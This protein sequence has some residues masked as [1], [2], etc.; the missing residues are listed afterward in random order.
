MYCSSCGYESIQ[1]LQYCKHC[2]AN[3]NPAESSMTTKKPTG[4][5]WIIVFGIAMMMGLPMGG[6]VVIFER[7]PG[8]LENGFPLWFLMTLAVI[9]LLM[10]SVSTVLLHRLLSPLFKAY[11]QSG[12]AKESMEPKSSER[13]RGQIDAARDYVSSVTEDTTRAFEQLHK[14]QDTQ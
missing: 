2:G 5:V 13:A 6:I 7:I 10:V 14:E 9:S 1:G 8:L 3:L 4:L 11:L 12:E